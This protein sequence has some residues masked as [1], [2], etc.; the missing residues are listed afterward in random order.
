MKYT[1]LLVFRVANTENMIL[2]KENNYK[3]RKRE[4]YDEDER[5]EEN[6]CAAFNLCIIH[7]VYYTRMYEF[8]NVLWFC[9]A[10]RQLKTGL[11][12]SG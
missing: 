6:N 12:S 10:G 5:K 1:S 4:D 3:L 9:Y 2:I 7:S 8:K 11:V